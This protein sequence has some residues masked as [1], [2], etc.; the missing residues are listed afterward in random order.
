MKTGEGGREKRGKS[1]GERKGRKEEEKKRNDTAVGRE[2]LIIF[3]A[4]TY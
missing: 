4:G 2:D 3:K 1:N